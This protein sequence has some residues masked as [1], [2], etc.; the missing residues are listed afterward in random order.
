VGISNQRLVSMNDDGITFRTKNGDTVTVP[1]QVFLH[2]FLQHVLPD[3]FVKIRHYGLMASSNA[4]TKLERARELL[5][6]MVPAPA[7][8]AADAPLPE[9]TDALFFQDV[10]LELTGIDVRICPA[11]HNRSLMR[12]A[13]PTARSRAPPLAA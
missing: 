8:R 7:C 2:R 10:L 9:G 4:T 5:T 3:G 13:L 6:A 1:P 12:L 11:C